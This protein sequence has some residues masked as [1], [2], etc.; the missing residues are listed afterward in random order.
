MFNIYDLKVI[1][2]IDYNMMV[3]SQNK[4]LQGNGRPDGIF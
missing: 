4:H 2:E 1:Q 3:I